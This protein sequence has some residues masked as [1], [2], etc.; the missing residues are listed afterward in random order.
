MP[1]A[2]DNKQTL[3]PEIGEHVVI[4]P[5]G[6]EREFSLLGTISKRTINRIE[7]TIDRGQLDRYLPDLAQKRSNIVSVLKPVKVEVEVT[8]SR[9]VGGVHRFNTSVPAKIVGNSAI[10]QMDIPKSVRKSQ[11]R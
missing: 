5:R 8:Y 10:L 11:R 3:L 7:S 4:R 6:T 2:T 1:G 9:E